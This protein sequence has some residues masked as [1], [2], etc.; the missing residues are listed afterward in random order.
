MSHTNCFTA[1]VVAT[2]ILAGCGHRSVKSVPSAFADS[3]VEN[4]DSHTIEGVPFAEA[5]ANVSDEL[6]FSVLSAE[7]TNLDF[8][9]RWDKSAEFDRVFYSQNTGGGVCLGVLLI[10][11]YLNVAV[12]SESRT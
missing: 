3:H 1:V 7:Q 5:T 8:T 9:I 11:V 4:V 2:M 12:C 10:V 6:Q